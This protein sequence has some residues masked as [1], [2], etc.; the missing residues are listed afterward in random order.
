MKPCLPLQPQSTQSLQL[1]RYSHLRV[2][3]QASPSTSSSLPLL[4][5]RKICSCFR[6]LPPRSYVP[7]PSSSHILPDL[8]S[9]TPVLFLYLSQYMI[10]YLWVHPFKVYLPYRALSF[11]KARIKSVLVT[12]VY[13]LVLGT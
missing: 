8:S 4:F 11:L 9:M 5:T 3:A 2:F 12:I 6:F 1:P 7:S 13:T 10:I